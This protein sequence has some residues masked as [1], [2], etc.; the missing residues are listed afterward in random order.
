VPAAENYGVEPI[1][2]E[3]RTVRRR[4]LFAINFTF[5][6]NPVMYVLGG[7]AVGAGAY[8]LLAAPQRAWTSVAAPAAS[9]GGE[10]R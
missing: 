7:L 8:L 6:L 5:F 10:S 2:A 1:P 3:F 4:D 9:A